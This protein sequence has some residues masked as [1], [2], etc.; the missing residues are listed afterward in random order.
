ML[1][2][3]DILQKWVGQRAKLGCQIAAAAKWRG[4]V[5]ISRPPDS[6]PWQFK[7]LDC[8]TT[9]YQLLLKLLPKIVL[10]F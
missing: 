4:G 8:T 10:K 9:P 1:I 3:L 7:Q 6:K 5:V 2:H